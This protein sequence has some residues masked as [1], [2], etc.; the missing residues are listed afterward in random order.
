MSIL[1]VFGAG[2]SFGSGAVQPGPPP[3]GSNLF[4][5]LRK[6]SPAWASI[7]VEH[8]EAFRADFEVGMRA[9]YDS[10]RGNTM[11][12]FALTEGMARFF[13]EFTCAHSN[14]YQKVAHAI[15]RSRRRVVLSSLNYDLL[16]EEAL[17]SA[18]LEYDDRML[19]I[20]RYLYK[21]TT[22]IAPPVGIPLLKPH[23][24]VNFF[25]TSPA[26]MAP[27]HSLPGQG[28]GEPFIDS[29]RPDLWRRFKLGRTGRLSAVMSHFMPTKEALFGTM[30]LEQVRIILEAEVMQA[31]Q[32]C[33]VGVALR[34]DDE[35][36][37]GPIRITSAPLMYIGPDGNTVRDWCRAVGRSRFAWGGDSFTAALP[38]LTRMISGN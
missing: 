15:R 6:Q 32:V 22:E 20:S 36:I 18:A 2:S 14:A 13:G 16:L 9:Y 11:D 35:H 30:A 26:V 31:D 23:G 7:S 12:L 24:S 10:V 17:G 5:E 29:L 3:L 27:L 4:D 34:P 37:W 21:Q 25:D 38:T 28:A 33:I 19:A 8:T 1:L